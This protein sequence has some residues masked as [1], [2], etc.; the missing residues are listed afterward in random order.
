MAHNLSSIWAQSSILIT[1]TS[2]TFGLI[3]PALVCGLN[4][5]MKVK[6]KGDDGWVLSDG[7]KGWWDPKG[8]SFSYFFFSFKK[9]KE[10]KKGKDMI[11]TTVPK[12]SLSFGALLTDHYLS[13]LPLPFSSF[14]M[15]R[16]KKKWKM[17]SKLRA[18]TQDHW[19]LYLSRNLDLF[20]SCSTDLRSGAA[21][22]DNK[23]GIE[24]KVTSQIM[25]QSSEIGLEVTF[26]S[27][28][29]FSLT[30]NLL[31]SIKFQSRE[32]VQGSY[33]PGSSSSFPTAQRNIR[34]R[35][36]LWDMRIEPADGNFSWT[37]HLWTSLSR[38]RN[39]EKGKTNTRFL[40]REDVQSSGEKIERRYQ[41][42]K[43]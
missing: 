6:T 4:H 13:Y 29:G 43:I 28:S 35:Q 1:D 41:P 12:T 24:M 22:V 7:A 26:A 17:R 21:V 18:R 34:K 14:R 39:E 31:F 38:N 23:K 33:Q 5:Q 32:S 9:K 30:W 37:H 15:K 3:N 10:K 16:R 27:R 19:T 20:L 2:S 42:M 25:E 8:L 11:E 40:E 36:V